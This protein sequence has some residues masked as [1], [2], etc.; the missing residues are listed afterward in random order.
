MNHPTA[1]H[2][3]QLFYNV[4]FAK[5]STIDYRLLQCEYVEQ[6]IVEGV[7]GPARVGEPEVKKFEAKDV[8]ATASLFCEEIKGPR[9]YRFFVSLDIAGLWRES[10]DAAAALLLPA[11]LAVVPAS[12]VGK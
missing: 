11:G 6:L 2:F 1:D 9:Q 12:E 5:E 4:E 8:F 7:H 10:K 3:A